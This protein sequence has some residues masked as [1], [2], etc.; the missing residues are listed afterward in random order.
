MRFVS[1]LFCKTAMCVAIAS[2]CAFSESNDSD[3]V[4][5][6]AKDTPD[7]TKKVTISGY[8]AIESGEIES[9][10]YGGNLYLPINHLWLGHVFGSLAANAKIN[11]NFSIHLSFESRLWYTS[12]LNAVRDN[13][14]FGEPA[15]NFDIN[16]TNAVGILNFGDP[17]RSFFKIGIGRFEYKYDPYAQDLGEYLFR[18][19]CYP[20]YIVTNFDLPLARL[21]GILLSWKLFD[22]FRQD[23]IVNTMSDVEPFYGINVSYL[24]DVNAGKIFDFGVGYQFQNMIPVDEVNDEKLSAHD[25][26][27][28][29]YLNSAGDTSYYTFGGMKLMLRFAFDPK[30]FGGGPSAAVSNILGKNGG[31]VYAEATVLGLQNY[32]SSTKYDSTN[33]SSN[34]YGYDDIWQKTPIMFGVNWP[35]HPFLSYGLMPLAMAMFDIDKFKNNLGLYGGSGVLAG[36]IAGGGTWLL[37]KWLN[38]DLRLDVLAV[39]GEWYGSRYP[40][41]YFNYF[42]GIDATPSNLGSRETSYDYRHDDWKW[43]ITAQKTIFGGLSLIGMVGRDHMHTQTYITNYEDYEETLIKNSNWVWMFKAKYSF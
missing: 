23:I 8:G 28:N 5:Q 43:A 6:K 36:I 40:D 11:D 7:W 33:T 14:T 4:E 19:G 27:Q 37:E 42:S 22:F 17:K 29:G 20:A 24:A 41:S 21:S 31:V 15:Q 13:S 32:P 34:P 18:T 26:H 1:G 38:T 9:G 39:E 30:Q 2:V 16:I 12:L 35:T 10:H 3:Q 25:Y